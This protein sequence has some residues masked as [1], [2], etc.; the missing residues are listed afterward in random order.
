MK[1]INH[2]YDYMPSTKPLWGFVRVAS[3]RVSWRGWLT[4]AESLVLST[5]IIERFLFTR[6]SPSG[7]RW[8]DAQGFLSVG[9]VSRSSTLK[10]VREANRL[11]W[12]LFPPVCLVGH[13]PRLRHVQGSTPTGVFEGRCRPFKHTSLGF[14]LD[15][16]PFVASSLNLWG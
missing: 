9:R 14:L 8:C 13:F 7:H 1:R 16:A 4:V 10:I 5:K 3:E 12:L 15:V 2:Y 11:W 6:F